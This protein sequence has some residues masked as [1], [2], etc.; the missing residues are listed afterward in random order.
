M[1]NPKYKGIDLETINQV[2]KINFPHLEHESE[3]VL[4]NI[5][6]SFASMN[7]DVMEQ[8]I[9]EVNVTIDKYRNDLMRDQEMFVICEM[10]KLYLQNCLSV[11][12]ILCR[13]ELESES[14]SLSNKD[15]VFAIRQNK[16][17]SIVRKEG[18]LN[19]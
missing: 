15:C 14:F 16:A 9:K 18:G 8:W 19:E 6:E 17:L 13:L 7:L 3:N 5:R 1:I 12:R 4:F 11:K 2:E 10:A